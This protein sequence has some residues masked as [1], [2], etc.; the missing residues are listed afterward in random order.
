MKIDYNVSILDDLKPTNDIY[1][2]IRTVEGNMG[3]VFPLEIMVNFQEPINKDLSKIQDKLSRI[4]SLKVKIEK[5]DKVTSANSVTDIISMALI[6][7]GDMAFKTFVNKPEDR[8][9]KRMS[10]YVSKDLKTIRI[11]GRMINIISFL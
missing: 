5:L 3:G 9:S 10:P 11:S 2:D 6:Y 4:D 1:Q 7:D 8:L